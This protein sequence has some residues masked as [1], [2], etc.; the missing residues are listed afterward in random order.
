LQGMKHTFRVTKAFSQ[1]S[2][3]NKL[4]PVSNAALQL[5]A[6]IRMP[7]REKILKF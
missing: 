4:Q 5:K 1:N 6:K 7:N 3:G 2:Y